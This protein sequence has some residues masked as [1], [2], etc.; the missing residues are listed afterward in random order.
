MTLPVSTPLRALSIVALSALAACSSV[1]LEPTPAAP[2]VVAAPAAVAAPAPGAAAAPDYRIDS[3]WLCRPGRDDI[4]SQPLTATAQGGGSTQSFRADPA[5]PVDC[6]YVYPTI[7]NDPSANSD[8]NAGPEEKRV[9]QQ[10]L[11]PFGSQCR[12]FAPV[13]R[14]VTLAALRSRFTGGT[15]MA[16]DAQ[17]ALSDVRA[18]WNDYMA[19]DNK[20]RGVVLIGH[21]QGARMLAGL[22]AA[23]IDGKPVQRQ[24]VSALLLGTNIAVP[25][26][27]DVGGAFKNLPL[28]RSSNQ[29]GCVVAYASFRA[30]A[31]PPADTLFG[32]I[33][34][35]A[36]GGTDP[37]AFSVACTNP[38][39]LAG[40]RGNLQAL[41]PVRENLMGQP[42]TSGVWGA[43]TQSIATTFL[44]SGSLPAECVENGGASYLAVGLPA[45]FPGDVTRNGEVL[46]NWGLHL[47]DVNLAMGNLVQLVQ[48]QSRAYA[49]KR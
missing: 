21:S 37:A 6:F 7:S 19:R 11:A 3:H 43:Q 22:I 29:T 28:C 40:G 8:L 30:D 12:M 47:V 24:I 41:L 2:A 23:E 48:Q 25:K 34:A 33:G 44:A 16:A 32:R 36:I 31:P 38:A 5:A 15:P 27:R 39:A 46:R 20:G 42:T 14:Q 26:G 17:M 10:Q 18:A 45:E 13:Y 35:T 4:C 49:A 9:A 1:S